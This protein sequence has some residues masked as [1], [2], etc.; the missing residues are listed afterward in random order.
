MKK[1]NI[2]SIQETLKQDVMMVNTL[3][4]SASVQ[5]L[6]LDRII[7]E[8]LDK[9]EKLESGDTTINLTYEDRLKFAYV[10]ARKFASGVN[11]KI[12]MQEN[13][14]YRG[15]GYLCLE[16]NYISFT[17]TEWFARIAEFAD[18]TEAYPLVNG[19]VV[20]NFTFHGPSQKDFY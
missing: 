16:G 12:Q 15:M 17:N 9:T 18:N 20:L 8:L 1:V 11:I 3:A 14:P 7:S 10:I 19:R 6:D 5:S 4:P 13:A 2:D